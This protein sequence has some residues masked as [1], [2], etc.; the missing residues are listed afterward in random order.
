MPKIYL[1]SPPQIEDL[2]AFI[3]TLEDIFYLPEKPALFQ[4]RLKNC[5]VRHIEN[6]MNEIIPV[7]TKHGV[8]FIINDSIALAI[9]YNVGLHVGCNDAS[10]QDCKDFKSRSSKHIGVSCY[11]SIERAKQFE[12]I[13]DC[14]SF[15]AMFQTQT[16]TEA[17]IC[18]PNVIQEYAKHNPSKEIAI[19]GGINTENLGEIADILPLVSYICVISSVW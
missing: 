19:I 5:E 4:L 16:K 2:G 9:K 17:K 7:C 18:R 15:G 1:I 10:I 11:N 3:S 13:A 8:E 14:I 6:C 12:N